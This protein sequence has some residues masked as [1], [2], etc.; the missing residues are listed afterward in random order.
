MQAPHSRKWWQIE[1]HVHE[2][3]ALE[4]TSHPPIAIAA[5]ITANWI[6]FA[7]EFSSG[8]REGEERDTQINE[9]IIIIWSKLHTIYVHNVSELHLISFIVLHV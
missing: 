9:K 4:K 8:W 6:S 7:L 5:I 1:L 2:T 3:V